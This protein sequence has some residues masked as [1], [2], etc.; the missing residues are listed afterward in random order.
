MTD[1]ETYEKTPLLNATA[2]PVNVVEHGRYIDE[3]SPQAMSMSRTIQAEA[4]TIEDFMDE[5]RD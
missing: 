3:S 2:I 4:A 5:A 1:K